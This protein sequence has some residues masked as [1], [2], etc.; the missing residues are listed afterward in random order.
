MIGRGRA[1]VAGLVGLALLGAGCRLP[2]LKQEEARA[3]ALPQTSFVYAADGSLITS[4]HSEQNR[5]SV[6]YPDIPWTVRQAVIAIEDRRFYLHR[7]VDLKALLRALYV[8]ARTGR[9]EEGGSTIT[10]QYIKNRYLGSERTLKRKIEEAWLAWQLEHRLTKEAILTHYL[11]T[12][13]FG[14][15][16]Y[17]I[18]AA[19]KTYFS[20]PV[21]KLN[22]PQADWAQTD[23]GKEIVSTA[24]LKRTHASAVSP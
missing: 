17:G 7:G 24:V 22:L 13:Y 14:H 18:Q 15:G 23:L 20:E 9:I 4:F 21:T 5:V 12:V 2:T 8:D 16:A 6:G 10:E 19:A 1:T 11:N 3:R